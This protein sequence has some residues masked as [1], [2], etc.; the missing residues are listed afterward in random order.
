MSNG[1]EM[2]K[3][4]LVAAVTLVIAAG[5]LAMAGSGAAITRSCHLPVIGDVVQVAVANPT[6]ASV[7]DLVEVQA[8]VDGEL[9]VA[10]ETVFLTPGE[11]TSVAVAFEGQVQAV[12]SS[13]VT[14]LG[15][16]GDEAT[17]F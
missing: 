14:R 15:F 11:T 3:A 17:P 6:S 12:V 5:T 4:V 7:T 10:Q 8:V 16:I 1:R 9:V 13:S 2:R